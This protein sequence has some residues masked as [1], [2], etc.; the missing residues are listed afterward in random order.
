MNTQNWVHIDFEYQIGD[1]V[2]AGSVNMNVDG[3]VTPKIFRIRAPDPGIPVIGDIT[4]IILIMETTTAP[5]WNLFGDRAVLANGIVLRKTDGSYQN[6]FTV[7]DNSEFAAIMYDLDFLD[8]TRFAS[9]GVK[10][11]LTF[12]GQNKIGVA[13]RL[14]IGEDLELIIQD[15]LT[16][17][18]KFTVLAEGHVV[19]D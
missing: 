9:Y 8:F 12:A 15:D 16:S 5:E 14:D 2:S 1:Q 11:R 3:S 13:I 19:V 10:G 17:L 6:I 7:K 4:R 18:I